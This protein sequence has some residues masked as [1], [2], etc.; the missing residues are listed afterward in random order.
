MGSRIEEISFERVLYDF[1]GITGADS[2]RDC[3]GFSTDEEESGL[4][5][6][7]SSGG[8]LSNSALAP[9]GL[10]KMRRIE[11]VNVHSG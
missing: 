6:L 7:M 10:C 9:W 1:R 8:N 11:W 3:V 4:E 5:W 2:T